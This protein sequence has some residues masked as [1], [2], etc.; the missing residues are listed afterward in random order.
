[1]KKVFA[2]TAGL[3]IM[4]GAAVLVGGSVGA[5]HDPRIESRAASSGPGFSGG[6]S[7]SS[8]DWPK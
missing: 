4:V 7:L 8:W 1:M 6:H 2:T 5:A 3:L